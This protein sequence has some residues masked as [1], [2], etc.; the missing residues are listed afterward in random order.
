LGLAG[1]EYISKLILGNKTLI[2]LDLYNCRINE[3]GGS[4]VGT[5]LKQNFCIEKLSIGENQ[6]NKKDIETIQLSVVFNTNYNQIKQNHQKYERESFA[7]NLIAEN[8][9]KW[10]STSSFVAQKLEQRLRAN[11]N[12]SLDKQIA[13]VIFDRT[14][15]VD[16]KP[17]PQS[18]EYVSGDGDIRF[19]QK[20]I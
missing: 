10:A 5:A 11:I 15:K 17:V 20:K 4:L 7:H 16:L 18:H 12:D 14:G 1:S 19:P 2:E 8:L 9:K 6:I 13:D 3:A